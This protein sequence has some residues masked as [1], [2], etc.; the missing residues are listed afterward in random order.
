MSRPREVEGRD[1]RVDRALAGAL[2]LALTSVLAAGGWWASSLSDE[3]SQGQK[4]V[5]AR[6][7]ELALKLAVIEQRQ[8]EGIQLRVEVKRL[9]DRIEEIARE[10]ARRTNNVWRVETLAKELAEAKQEITRVRE[11]LANHERLGGH[12]TAVESLDSLR[13]RIRKLEEGQ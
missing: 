2:S 1:R 3:V 5:Q 9:A 7:A 8:R 13:E 11:A 10:Q 6:L 12:G 4:A